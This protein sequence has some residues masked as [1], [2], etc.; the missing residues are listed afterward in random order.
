MTSS[1][2]VAEY[3]LQQKGPVTS[4]KL[5]KLVYYSQAWSLALEQEPLFEEPIEAWADGPI[6][7]NLMQSQRE[8]SHVSS[9]PQGD[10]GRLTADQKGTIDAVIVYYGQKSTQ[11]LEEMTNAEDP[12][13]MAREQPSSNK[14]PNSKRSGKTISHKAMQDYYSGLEGHC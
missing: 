7:R 3:I 6:V 8:Q 2:D 5:Q 9:I 14:P 11:W 4:I 13:R 10:P 12:W 1:L